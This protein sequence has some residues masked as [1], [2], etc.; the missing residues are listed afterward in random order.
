MASLRGDPMLDRLDASLDFYKQALGLR[1]QREQVL[2]AN[3]ANADTPNY[4]ARDIDFRAALDQALDKGS[5]APQSSSGLA[6]ATTSAR[7]IAGQGPAT[8]AAADMGLKYRIP[9]Q[10]SLDGN[11]V[12]MNN[13]RVQFMNNSLHYQS[14]LKILGN[15]IKAMRT[16]MQPPQ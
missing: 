8:S 16:A 1:R 12:D 10:P 3:I 14:D 5:A 11:T 4:K 15:Q 6:L 13:E 9:Y 2:A 7:H